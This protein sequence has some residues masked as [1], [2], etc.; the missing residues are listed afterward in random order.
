[1]KKL[2]TLTFALLSGLFANGQTI[3]NAGLETWHS[4]NSAGFLSLQVPDNGWCTLDSLVVN[5]IQTY[6]D[7]STTQVNSGK[8]HQQAFPK[9]G[10][11]HTSPG[12]AAQ[13]VTRYQDTTLLIP[14]CISNCQMAVDI[15]AVGTGTPPVDALQFTGGTNISTAPHRPATVG[16]WIQ[17]FPKG[18]D[19]AHMKINI[20]NASGS[21]IGSVDTTITGTISTYTHIAPTIAYTTPTGYSKL[22]VIFSSSP[23]ADGS[24]KDSSILYVD[25]VA[26]NYATGVEETNATQSAVR[27]YPNPST[28]VVY[29]YSNVADKLSWQVYNT[30]GQVV[31][32]KEL[33]ANNRE[34]LSYLAAGTYFYNVMNSKGEIVQKDKFVIA[35]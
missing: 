29:L 25:D 31:V 23:L 11:V 27:F 8:Y 12:V 34:D 9:N 5:L 35:K 33:V 26:I 16:A 6:L 3:S 19:T 13:L 14:G 1:M 21:I 30:N 18:L 17:Y 15:V 10:P 28:G 22:Q 20:L 7:M 32:N 4:A 24:G 2:F